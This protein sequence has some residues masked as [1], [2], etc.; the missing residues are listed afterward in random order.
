MPGCIVLFGSYL[1]GEDTEESDIDLF[2]EA[3][4]KEI[5]LERFEGLLKRKIE[6]HFRRDFGKISKELKNNIING[7]VMQ[8]YL[9]AF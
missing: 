7:L 6:L 2:V 4:K 8:G 5:R 1:R 9:E 3:D